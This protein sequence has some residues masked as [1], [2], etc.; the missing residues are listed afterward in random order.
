MHKYAGQG[1][2]R[3][4]LRCF[5][6]NGWFRSVLLLIRVSRFFVVDRVLPAAFPRDYAPW[7]A[8]DW[9]PSGTFFDRD[10]RYGDDGL[11]FGR[12]FGS[13]GAWQYYV[14]CSVYFVL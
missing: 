10:D 5:F 3:V 2:L 12:G 11:A 8:L 14:F 9:W 7:L 6:G 1:A 4:V 13:L